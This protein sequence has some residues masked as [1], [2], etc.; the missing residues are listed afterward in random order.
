MGNTPIG[1]YRVKAHVI[2]LKNVQHYDQTM[3]Q[4]GLAEDDGEASPLHM[5]LVGP[6]GTAK[7]PSLACC[8]RRRVASLAGCP[9]R[10]L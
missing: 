6:P 4:H 7:R 10:R 2:E 5:A 8:R 3:A 9:H 1:L